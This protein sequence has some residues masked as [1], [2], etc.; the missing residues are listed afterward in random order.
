MPIA[1]VMQ[2]IAKAKL[3]NQTRFDLQLYFLRPIITFF[4]PLVLPGA[5]RIRV[6]AFHPLTNTYTALVQ[7]YTNSPS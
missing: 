7:L 6:S 4:T 3:T 1:E 2:G 5:T